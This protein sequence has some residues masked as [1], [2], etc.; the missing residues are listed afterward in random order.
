VFLAVLLRRLLQRVGRDAAWPYVRRIVPLI[1]LVGTW[2]GTIAGAA[3]L[4]GRE[5]GYSLRW[6]GAL[7][8]VALMVTISLYDR[9]VLMPSLD[10]AF[11]RLAADGDPRWESDW[12]FL[13]RMASW[14]RALTLLMAVAAVL[15]MA[16]PA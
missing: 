9:A 3:L 11:R 5:G 6:A 2:A 8:L 1:D 16:F 10:A 15:L 13:W 7:G 4:F 14:G 12:R